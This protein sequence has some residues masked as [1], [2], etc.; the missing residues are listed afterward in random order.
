[1]M[2]MRC[3][4]RRAANDERGTAMPNFSLPDDV[5]VRAADTVPTPFHLYD[6]AGIRSAIRDVKE[7]FAWAPAFREYFAVKALPNPRVLE[8]FRSENCGLDCSSL[9][10]LILAQRGGFSG[11]EIMFS[12]NAMPPDEYTLAREMGA[13]INLDDL[14]D[15]DTLLSH[16]GV[17][18]EICLR[19]N[20]GGD[21]RGGSAIMGQPGESKYGM[22]RPQ[23]SQAL[24]RLK[25]LGAKRF[26]L[27]AL[28]ASNSIDREYYPTLA[29]LLFTVGRDLSAECGLPLS[30]VNLSGGIGIPYR[31][32]EKPND[33][34]AIG[35]AVRK[36]YEEIF[37]PVSSSGPAICTEMGRFMT[38]PYGWLVTRAVH[39]KKIY[40]DYIGVDACASCLMRPAMYG[41]YHH[42]H[43]AGKRDKAPDHVY[44]VTGALCENNDKFAWDRPLPEIAVGDLIIIHDTGAHGLAMGYQYNGRLRCAEVLL[45]ENGELRLIRRAETPEDYFSTL[46]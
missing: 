45:K 35:N 22:T 23:L 13:V 24:G 15:I 16:G 26:G 6:E 1:M 7:A 44:D 8:I 37:G 10:E 9:C 34:R 30:F 20:P 38:G 3:P 36:V 12:A 25:A 31:P 32:E 4:M 42:I 28:L 18:E 46:V 21:L 33:I 29:R 19:F 39:E 11:K 41:A 40:K 5:F 27:H 14:T 43:V 2:G 17:P